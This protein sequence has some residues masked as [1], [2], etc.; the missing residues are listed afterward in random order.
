M[1]RRPVSLG[2]WTNTLSWSGWDRLDPDV[3]QDQTGCSLAPGQL[4]DGG[5][6]LLTAWP[7]EGGSPERRETRAGEEP[8]QVA[9]SLWVLEDFWWLQIRQTGGSSIPL[10]GGF[11]EPRQSFPVEGGAAASAGSDA[12]AQDSEDVR[13]FWSPE[14]EETLLCWFSEE[15]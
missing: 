7:S 8:A 14:E 10:M 4:C 1:G 5:F 6:S 11:Y 15:S 2:L 12:A 13:M 3:E 9:D